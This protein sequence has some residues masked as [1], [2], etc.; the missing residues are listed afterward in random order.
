MDDALFLY[1]IPPRGW[2]TLSLRN[3]IKWMMHFSS[4][5]YLQADDTLFGP[6]RNTVKWMTHLFSTKYH[7]I[8]DTFFP[9]TKYHQVDGTLFLIKIPWSGWYTF[10]LQSAIKWMIHFFSTK[11]FQVDDTQNTIAE[12]VLTST[13]NLCFEQK[14]E[15]CQNFLSEIFHFFFWW[16]NFQYI[17]IVCFRNRQL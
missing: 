16:W 4:R 1:E 11:H 10:P 6:L 15:K 14:Y 5:K 13:H 17:W 9:S 8:D 3:T 7:Q 12:V 2:Y